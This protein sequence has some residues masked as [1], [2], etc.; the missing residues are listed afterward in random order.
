MIERRP[1]VPKLTIDATLP[2]KLLTLTYPVELVDPQ[3][4]VV[5]RYTPVSAVRSDAME[6]KISEEELDRR[7]R[8]GGGR[9]LAAIMADLNS[10]R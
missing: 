9:T 3:G 4:R 8:Q 2:E 6:P 10:W 1:A 7:E 5:G